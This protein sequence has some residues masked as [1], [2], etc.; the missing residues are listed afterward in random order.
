LTTIAVD[1]Q[2][3]WRRAWLEI[4]IVVLTFPLLTTLA[5]S[6]E[7]AGLAR[8]TRLGRLAR[9]GAVMTRAGFVLTRIFR[10]R[11]LAYILALTVTLAITFGVIFG[12]IEDS[13]N[14]ADGIWWAFV[15][16]TTV[17]YGDFF[18]STTAGRIVAG[19]LM[20]VGIG[21]VATLTATVAAHFMDDQE[22]ELRAEIRELREQLRLLTGHIQ[23]IESVLIEHSDD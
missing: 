21:F 4:L 16:I 6:L 11:G 17:G 23:A 19:M 14:V 10:K 12:L 5:Q 15:T 3:Y 7:L 2:A 1:R 18:P 8:L 22:D 20:V 13:A 9:F